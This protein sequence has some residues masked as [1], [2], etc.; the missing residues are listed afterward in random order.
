LPKALVR[1]VGGGRG[2]EFQGLERCQMV[3]ALEGEEGLGEATKLV[4]W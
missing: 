2:L 4:V 1:V 3:V